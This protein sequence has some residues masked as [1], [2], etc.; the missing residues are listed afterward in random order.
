MGVVRTDGRDNFIN[1][2]EI[3]AAREDNTPVVPEVAI[4]FENKL[5]RGNRTNKFN[6]ENFNAFLS[7]KTTSVAE[8]GVHIRYNRNVI[9]KPNFKN[10]K[11][12][13]NLDTNVAVLKLF[14]GISEQV[15]C[16]I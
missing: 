6:A 15:V 12:H 9:L 4:Y 14:P 11:V 13:T 7:G 5:L 16:N 8:V 3:A 10:L 1:A 2:V